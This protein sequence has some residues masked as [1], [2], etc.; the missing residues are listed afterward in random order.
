MDFR[1]LVSAIVIVS[2]FF[3]RGVVS[4]VQTKYTG[5]FLKFGVGVR[6]MSLGGAVVS[7]SNPAVA[8]YW[9]PA[10]LYRS[11]RSLL[12]MM[13]SEEFA[14]VLK[15][16]NLSFVAGSAQKGVLGIGFIRI[17]VDSIHYL[18][19]FIQ[20]NVGGNEGEY[21]PD[22]SELKFFNSSLG[23]LYF[24]ISNRLKDNILYGINVKFPYERLYKGFA[25]GI[26][27]DVGILYEFSRYSLGIIARDL[28]G[29]L[30]I[31]ND[32]YKELILPSFCVGVASVFMLGK[33]IT[34][35]E[36]SFCLDLSTGS[37]ENESLFYLLFANIRARVGCE[38]SI[39]KALKVRFG[40]D[41]L[42][43]YTAGIG[44]SVK[45]IN[46]D[47]GVGFGGRYNELGVSHRVGLIVD[48]NS[49]KRA[50]LEWLED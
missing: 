45:F 27:L 23:A 3:L 17:G 33:T 16:D 39:K 48:I 34:S 8:Y 19:D 42:G 5:E 36:P 24:S 46:I 2:L 1:R 22:Y 13:H 10:I 26:G 28:T 15:Y 6:E 50:F 43:D 29:T 4:G 11:N 21:R 40:R 18:Q 9:N 41:E 47:Y 30:V 44:I 37:K 14:G 25:W 35:I 49:F 20:Y 38:I 32:G 7:S 31:W 12:Q